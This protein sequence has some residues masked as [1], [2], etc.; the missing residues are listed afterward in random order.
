MAAEDIELSEDEIAATR[1]ALLVFTGLLSDIRIDEPG[2]VEDWEETCKENAGLDPD[3][4]LEELLISALRKF[5]EEDTD[6]GEQNEAG[7]D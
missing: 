7:Q 3:C 5:K 6:H 4:N 2:E 1:L